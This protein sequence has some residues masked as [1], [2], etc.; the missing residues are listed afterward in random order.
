VEFRA[1]ERGPVPAFAVPNT[2]TPTGFW[3]ECFG[4]PSSGM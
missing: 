2:L 3:M 4:D 1:F